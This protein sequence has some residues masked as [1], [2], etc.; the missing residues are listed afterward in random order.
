MWAFSAYRNSQALI[1]SERLNEKRYEENIEI[2]FWEKNPIIWNPSPHNPLELLFFSSFCLFNM[3]HSILLLLIF[4]LQSVN[5]HVV[6]ASDAT[7]GFVYGKPTPVA[8]REAINNLY[9]RGDAR[10]HFFGI[11]SVHNRPADITPTQW[12]CR[13]TLPVI[14]SG[15]DRDGKLSSDQESR[16]FC[17]SWSYVIAISAGKQVYRRY[18]PNQT[19]RWGY[20]VWYWAVFAVD[21]WCRWYIWAVCPYWKGW[22][23]EFR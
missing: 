17:Y 4:L 15:Y 16:M 9:D 10:T 2:S 12:R 21:Q 22:T 23:C 6:T 3:T 18:L 11:P 19:P 1:A 7:C 8:C 5:V 20:Y 13:L 14:V